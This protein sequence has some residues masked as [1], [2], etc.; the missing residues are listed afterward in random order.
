[1][2]LTITHSHEVE[3]K[4]ELPRED[5]T[6]PPLYRT[7]TQ[8]QDVPQNSII[9]FAGNVKMRLS[10]RTKGYALYSGYILDVVLDYDTVNDSDFETEAVF[11]FPLSIGQTLFENFVVKMDDHDIV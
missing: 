9:G 3:V 6:Q 4:E 10:E 5:L 8:Q 11:T 7:V 1:V 2:E